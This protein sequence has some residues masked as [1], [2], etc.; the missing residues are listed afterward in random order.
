MKTLKAN[1][2]TTLGNI[3]LELWPDIAPET[4]GNFVSL[5][6][7]TREWTDPESGSTV[8]RPFYN[9]IIFHRVIDDFMI[10]TGCPI[11]NGTGGPG[12]EFSDECYDKNGKLKA[13]VDYGVIAMAN[14]GPDTNGS[15]FFIV[16]RK[17]GCEW[18][19]GKHT[20]FGKVIEGIEVA[21]QIEN[22]PRNPMDK[23]VKDVVMEEITIER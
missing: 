1:I 11:G 20:V 15:Q 7:G 5:A 17:A 22:L 14:A 18:L 19:N 16:T 8:K 12:Y 9:G 4:V 10:Q 2:K 13:K 3:V 6:E 23:P 21:H